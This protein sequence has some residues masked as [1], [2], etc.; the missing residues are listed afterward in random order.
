MGGTRNHTAR[1]RAGHSRDGKPGCVRTSGQ[2][3]RR[4]EPKT[5]AQNGGSAK[6]PEHEAPDE[7][8]EAPGFGHARP[9]LGTTCSPACG[10]S[11]CLPSASQGQYHHVHL[12]SF[13]LLVFLV[14]FFLIFSFLWLYRWLIRS[15]SFR[16]KHCNSTSVYAVLCSP[17]M[18]ASHPS[19]CM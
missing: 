1:S 17:P 3:T 15:Y 10:A 7:E 14:C 8:R 13:C 11:P 9:G 5:H 16:C 6:E 4:R 19:P 18:S 12:L 2:R